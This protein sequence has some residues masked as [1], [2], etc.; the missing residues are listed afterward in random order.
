MLHGEEHVD[1]FAYLREPDHPWT[2]RYILE[3]T[4]YFNACQAAVADFREKLYEELINEEEVRRTLE[5]DNHFVVLPALHFWDEREHVLDGARP[6][7]DGFRYASD[8][9]DWWLDHILWHNDEGWYSCED[10]T[11]HGD[12]FNALFHDGHV[13]ALSEERARPALQDPEE[14]E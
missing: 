12:R 9:N 6:V 1:D 4:K 11:R 13:Q 10:P 14:F 7:P 8:S 5:L 2:R 3:E